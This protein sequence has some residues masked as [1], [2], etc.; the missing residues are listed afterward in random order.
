MS[1]KAAMV[2]TTIADPALLEDYHANFLTHHHLEQI[3]II[4]IPDRKTPPSIFDRC[5]SLAKKGLS[6]CC[7]TLQEQESFLQKIGFDPEQI[8]YDSDNRRNVGYLMALE[9]PIDFLISIDDDNLCPSQ[10]DFFRE[11]SVVCGNKEDT[12]VVETSG[13]WF[14]ICSLMTVEPNISVYARGFPYFA[15]RQEQ[16]VQKHQ[17]DGS[18]PDQC[19]IVRLRRAGPRRDDLVVHTRSY[20]LVSRAVGRFGKSDM[21]A[22][23]YTEHS[24]AS[25]RDSKLLL[26]AHGISLV[27]NAH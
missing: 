10:E 20:H 23:E 13:G 19:R 7:P 21:V 22:R 5:A 17:D 12:C 16:K 9:E 1:L 26:C 18:Y 14:N 8:P 25:H 15:R 4:V 27:G 6:V 11:H 2:L 24:A 3:R